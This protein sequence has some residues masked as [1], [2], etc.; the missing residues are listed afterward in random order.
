MIESY[1]KKQREPI[2]NLQE[3][4]SLLVVTIHSVVLPLWNFEPVSS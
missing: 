3:S 2:H 1:R 4:D